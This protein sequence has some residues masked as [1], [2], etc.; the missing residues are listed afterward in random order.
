MRGEVG[1]RAPRQWQRTKPPSTWDYLR[2][3]QRQKKTATYFLSNTHEHTQIP[4][5][6]FLH[7]QTFT[8][9]G[10]SVDIPLDMCI[11]VGIPRY[12]LACR[13]IIFQ[14]SASDPQVHN[15]CMCVV[16]DVAANALSPPQKW[17]CFNCRILSSASCYCTRMLR[18]EESF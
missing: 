3:I 8:H 7:E 12:T 10:I 6:F 13:Y 18:D 16:K 17:T 11:P 2:F 1:G 5:F 4:P 9:S 14:L 15:L